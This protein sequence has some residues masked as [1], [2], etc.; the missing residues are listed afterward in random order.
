MSDVRATLSKSILMPI[1]ISATIFE[2]APIGDVTLSIVAVILLTS[3]IAS[4]YVIT[5]AFYPGF[6]YVA[7]KFSIS[8]HPEVFLFINIIQT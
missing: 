5:R 1:G 2:T 7:I 4:S 8:Y 3:V 6:L